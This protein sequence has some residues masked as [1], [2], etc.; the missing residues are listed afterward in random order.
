[1]A[2]RTTDGEIIDIFGGIDD[3]KSKKL[4]VLHDK[5]FEDDPT[6]ILRALKFFTSLW[7]YA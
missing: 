1:M 5:S 4:R 6:R 7:I 2:K 3:I